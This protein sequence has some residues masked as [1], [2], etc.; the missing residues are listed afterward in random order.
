MINIYKADEIDFNHNGL[1]I[2]SPIRCEIKEELN[3]NYELELK[4]PFDKSN[5]WRYLEEGNVIKAPTPAGSQL[6]R[7]YKKVKTL[8]NIT[9]SARHIFY[10]LVNNFLEDCRPTQQ[11]GSGALKWILNG[12]QYPHRFT[13]ISDITKVNSATYIRKNPVEVILNDDENSY[14]NR[15]GGELVRDNLTIKMLENRGMDRGVTIRYGKNLLGLECDVN[16]DTVVTRVMPTGLYENDTVLMLPEKYI[17]SPYINNY[18]T[19]RVQHYHFSDI[20]VGE[21]LTE[22]QALELLRQKANELFSIHKIDIP[23]SNTKVNFI[24]LS[25]TEEYKAYKILNQ[26][27]LGDTVTIKHSKLGIDIKAKMISYK[28]DSISKKYIEIEL[29]DFKENISSN[30]SKVN[31]VIND[32]AKELETNKSDF[33]KAIDN[34]T[35]LLTSALGGYVLKREDEILIMDNLDPNKA[36]KI[37]RWNIN[38]LGYSNTGINGQ[39][40]IAITMNGKI[41]AEF[42]TSIE[43]TANNIRGGTLSSLDG[44]VS[45]NLGDGS[46]KIGGNGQVAE[47]S[48]DYSKYIHQDNSYTEIN[49]KGL[50]RHVNGESKDYHYLNYSGV[51]S[52]SSTG[53]N[54]GGDATILLPSDFKNKDFNVSISFGNLWNGS[55]YSTLKYFDIWNIKTDKT[56]PKITF[57]YN[58]VFIDIPNYHDPNALNGMSVR[59]TINYSI[60]A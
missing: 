45:I 59:A 12:A 15:W 19:P 38:G 17:D 13:G 29:G 27:Y 56:V 54:I 4:H 10:D 46:F 44:S 24:E 20:K 16:L 43:V 57:K 53:A 3:S 47:H 14:M 49:N 26:I 33:Q 9:V 36:R 31:K 41:N 34:A 1:A 37:W 28:Y 30:F 7:I 21:D 40:G 48:S 51:L 55:A 58:A 22:T 50:I 11:D 60:V 2:L 25:K 32:V 18:H 8:N 39:F 5:K 6:F 23:I 42:I 35:E 52:Y